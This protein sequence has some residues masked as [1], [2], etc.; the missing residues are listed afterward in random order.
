ME[1]TA[2]NEV[3][4]NGFS[5]VYE[6]PDELHPSAGSAWGDWDGTEESAQHSADINSSHFGDPVA[7]PDLGE[8]AFLWDQPDIPRSVL[9]VFADGR[10]Y[11]ETISGPDTTDAR[12]GMLTQMFEQASS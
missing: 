3:A 2:T 12:R 10:Y 8:V 7:Q 11:T 5:C 9:L 6:V 1:Q 4:N